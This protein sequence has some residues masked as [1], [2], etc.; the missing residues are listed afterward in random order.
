MFF[1]EDEGE[2]KADEKIVIFYLRSISF[3]IAAATTAN[4]TKSKLPTKKYRSMT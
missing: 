3:T 2:R 1:P 4:P